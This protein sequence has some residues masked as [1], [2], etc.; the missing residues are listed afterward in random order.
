MR[1]KSKNLT[2]PA[3]DWA[4]AK[5]RGRHLVR[6]H[7]HFRHIA[8]HSGMSQEKIAQH[9]AF[10]QTDDWVWLNSIGS[11]E[12]IEPFSASW[13]ESGEF[14]F[15]ENI[16][17]APAGIPN[18]DA[19]MAYKWELEKTVEGWPHSYYTHAAQG[20]D[21]L[22]AG[23]RCFVIVKLGKV[24]DIPDDLIESETK[25]QTLNAAPK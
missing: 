25:K 9:L 4:I 7:D 13:K 2:G 11:M 17:F 22:T 19:W 23:L 18:G 3:L 16:G 12:P 5:A 21:P 20:P 6:R 15:K 8:E 10:T 1:V 14:I 24:V